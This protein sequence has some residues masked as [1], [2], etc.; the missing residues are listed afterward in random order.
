MPGDRIVSI[1][2]RSARS[3]FIDQVIKMLIGKPNT[4]V[5]ITVLRNGQELTFTCNRVFFPVE[6][7]GVEI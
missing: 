5:S 4:T 2:G 7:S 6:I 1:G 3:K